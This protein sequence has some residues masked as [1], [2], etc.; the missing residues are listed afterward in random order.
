MTGT[1]KEVA[2][3]LRRLS[4][5]AIDGILFLPIGAA[6]FFAVAFL[7]FSIA[8]FFWGLSA[9]FQ[10]IGFIQFAT[11]I[12]VVL[13]L[14]WLLILRI[15]AMN[16]GQIALILGPAVVLFILSILAYWFTGDG[17]YV[18]V[19]AAISSLCAYTIWTLILFSNGQTVGKR[20]VGIQSVREN[21]E[22][23][24]WGLIFVREILKSLLHIFVIGF[25]ID[26]IMLLSDKAERQSVADRIAGTIVVRI[27]G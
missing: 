26:G 2:T 4:S 25:I 9:G 23:A 5:W 14:G 24:G 7:W 22:S 27:S 17:V 16:T 8:G 18:A 3:P 11:V 15:A 12:Y 20:L 10:I 19:L 13:T 21:G 1:G 6:I